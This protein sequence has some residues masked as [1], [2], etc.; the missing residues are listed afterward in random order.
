MST[1]KCAQWI[2][3]S[4]PGRELILTGFP[5]YLSYSNTLEIIVVVIALE[6]ILPKLLHLQMWKATKNAKLFA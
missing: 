4:R 5:S 6:I 2:I 1:Q 3:P